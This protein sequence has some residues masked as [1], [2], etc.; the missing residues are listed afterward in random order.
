MNDRFF[1]FFFF[2]IALLALSACMR[3]P[4]GIQP[5]KNFDLERYM[6]TWYEIARL[7]HSFERHSDF[8]SATYT[9][10]ADGGITVL[11][12]GF[13]TK[14]Q[15]WKEAIGK[16]YFVNEPEVGHLKVSFF[17]PFYGSYVIFE[18]DQSNYQYAFIT[19]NSKDYLWL[20]ARTPH[21]S[22]ELKQHFIEVAKKLGFKTNQLIFPQ[23]KTEKELIAKSKQSNP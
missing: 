7:D 9:K 1:F 17:G 22:E 2:S 11:N 12:K 15:R 18:L 20:L 5:V 23:Q 8:V 13:N 6:G 19:S 21:V 4:S 16:A 14:K 10:R 3:L